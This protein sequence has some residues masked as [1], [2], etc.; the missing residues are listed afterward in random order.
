MIIVLGFL[1]F[2]QITTLFFCSF[3]LFLFCC[4]YFSSFIRNYLTSNFN[5][6]NNLKKKKK[7]VNLLQENYL[8]NSETKLALFLKN[9]YRL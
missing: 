2:I 5:S 4:F 3:I 8:N 1:I 6:N 7:N 9:I